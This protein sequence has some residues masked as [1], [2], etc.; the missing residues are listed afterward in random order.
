V[1]TFHA[2]LLMTAVPSSDSQALSSIDSAK[3]HVSLVGERFQM[4]P[5]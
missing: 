2:V 3:F 1:V 5:V 4:K